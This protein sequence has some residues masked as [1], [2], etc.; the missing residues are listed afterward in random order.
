MKKIYLLLLATLSCVLSAQ[1]Q[2]FEVDGISYNITK[3]A[4]D[5]SPGEVQV[6]GGEIKE[7]IIF[8]E[9]VVYAD[10]TYTVTAI[11]NSAFSGRYDSNNCTKK[12]V[13]PGTVRT[14]GE[15]AFYDNYYLEEVEFNEGLEAIGRSAFG[16]A[17]QLKDIRIPSTVTSIDADAF[18]TNQENLATI[19]CLATTPPNISSNSFQGRTTGPLHVMV[20]DVEAYRG[21]EN[22]KNFSEIVGGGI[23]GIDKC[24]SP[25]IT[26][27]DGSLSMSCATEAATIYYTTDGSAP[28]EN[29]IRYTSPIPYDATQ[30]IR[31]IAIAEGFESSAVRIFYDKEYI[32]SITSV[33]DEQ[34]VNYTMISIIQ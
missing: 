27:D 9:S 31:A 2:S 19:S 26:C 20:A 18:I 7:E 13:I 10:V 5:E 1:A 4:S 23:L 17:F 34:G 14:I 30:I 15:S 21:A 28:N 16:Y 12:Y 32:E 25:V 24:Y 8:P 29:A 33:I 3:Q 22:W 11:G 6:T